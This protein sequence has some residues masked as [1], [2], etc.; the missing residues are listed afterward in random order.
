VG[1]MSREKEA[2]GSESGMLRKRWRVEKKGER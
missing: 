2:I 1:K